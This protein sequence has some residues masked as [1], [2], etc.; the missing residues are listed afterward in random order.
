MPL[1]DVS[2]IILDPDLA[3]LF[4]LVRRNET[5]SAKGRSE[6]AEVLLPD[7][8]GVFCAATPDDLQRLPEEQRTSR[9]FSLV[10]K[11][12][13]RASG[14][15]FQPDVVRWAG[16]DYTVAVLDLYTR[17]GEGFVQA[18]VVSMNPADPEPV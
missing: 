10:T 9:A 18:I 14:I 7:Q 15:G 12:R 2:E 13:L 3:D 6:V 17:Y 16:V 1:L 11:T 5:I 4:V 8:V